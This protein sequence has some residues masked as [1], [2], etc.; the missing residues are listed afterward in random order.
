[1]TLQAFV[2]QNGIERRIVMAQAGQL[3]PDALM[4]EIAAADLFIPSTRPVQTDGSGFLPVL[5]EQQNGLCFAAAFTA[6]SRADGMAPYLMQALGAHFFRR[7]PPGYG[8]LVNPGTE[9]QI[10]LAP[11]GVAA[12]QHDLKAR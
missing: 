2:P 6:Q 7:L 8:V 4:G 10:F 3:P 12:L 9:A 1:M 5:L 11:D